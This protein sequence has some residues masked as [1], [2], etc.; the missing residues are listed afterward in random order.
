MT[1]APIQLLGIVGSLRAA[2]I[3]RGLL[4]AAIEVAPADVTITI[5]EGL[6]E[7]P[8]YDPDVD[9]VGAP[10]AVAALRDAIRAADGLLIATPEYNYS[11]PGVLKNALDWASRPPATTAMKGIPAGIMGATV[12]ISGTIRAQHHLRQI[13][14]FTETHVMLKPEVLIPKAAERFDADGN[15][16]DDST[17]DLLRGW[18]L[19][20]D[21]WVRRMKA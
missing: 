19:A 10:P 21:A 5:F 6:R 1:T 14:Q 3:N 11:V 9:K 17:R 4:R 18:M 15:L 12:G 7:I 20:L 16:T 8:P 2:S 13:L